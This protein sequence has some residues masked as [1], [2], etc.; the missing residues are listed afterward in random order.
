MSLKSISFITFALGF[1]WTSVI[2]PV[3]VLF[4]GQIDLFENYLYC[5][6]ILETIYMYAN[7]FY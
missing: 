2:I 4:M 5:I 3:R 6:E 7:Y 1:T